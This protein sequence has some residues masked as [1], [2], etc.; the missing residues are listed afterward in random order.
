MK[1]YDFALIAISPEKKIDSDLLCQIANTLYEAGADDCTVLSRDNAF[2]LEFDRE[3]DSYKKAVLSA[4][5]QV[6]S[7]GLIVKSIDAGQYVGLSDAAEFAHLTRSAMSKFSKGVRGDGFFP[8]PYFRLNNKAPLYEW[9]EIADWLSRKGMIEPE[10]AEN[11]E[12]TADINTILSLKNKEK[13]SQLIE[14][15]NEI[16]EY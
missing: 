8:T 16:F 1:E 11:A 13:L 5:K 9:K 4:I 2:I 7:V 14:L 12:V 6:Q 3:A 15:S 10:L